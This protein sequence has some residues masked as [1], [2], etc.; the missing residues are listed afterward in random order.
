MNVLES[1]GRRRAQAWLL[2]VACLALHVFDEAVTGF[3]DFYNPIVTQIRARWWFPVPRFTFGVW[4]G[5]LIVAIV[6]LLAISPALR[7][8]TWWVRLIATIFGAIMVLNGI[9]HLAA[10]IYYGRWVPGATTAPLILV[11]GAWLLGATWKTHE[12]Q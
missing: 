8:D 1:S 9:A 3:L 7:R 11:G 12:L 5:G 2:L 6:V 10:S 4:L